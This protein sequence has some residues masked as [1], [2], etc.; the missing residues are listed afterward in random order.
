MPHHILIVNDEDD[1]RL[2]L[3]DL[4]ESRGYRVSQAPDGAAGLE[5]LTSR[6]EG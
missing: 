1:V 5:L 3:E 2:V 6:G 4:F